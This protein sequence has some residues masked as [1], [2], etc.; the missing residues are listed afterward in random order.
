MG[1]LNPGP[2]SQF[3]VPSL[4]VPPSPQGLLPADR[5]CVCGRQWTSLR[6]LLV[7]TWKTLKDVADFSILLGLFV[8]I[9]SLLGMVL[10]A[11]R[12]HFDPDTGERD[13]WVTGSVSPPPPSPLL[14]YPPSPP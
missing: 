9:F 4:A 3:P 8:F 5:C 6:V 10:F 12:L 2:C 13:A 7:T 11:N 14:T 1:P